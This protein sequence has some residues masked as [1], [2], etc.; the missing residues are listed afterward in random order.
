[1]LHLK[2]K[3]FDPSDPPCYYGSWKIHYRQIQL[4]K[5]SFVFYFYDEVYAAQ[6]YSQV[7]EY[8]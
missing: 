5:K 1:M 8:L 7:F 2:M 6:P 4:I 3:Q